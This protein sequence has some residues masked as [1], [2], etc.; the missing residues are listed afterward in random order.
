MIDKQIVNKDEYYVC[1]LTAIKNSNY[2][3]EIESLAIKIGSLW[4]IRTGCDVGN[5]GKK[6]IKRGCNSMK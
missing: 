3:I 6:T 5:L 2:V 1:V 4:K